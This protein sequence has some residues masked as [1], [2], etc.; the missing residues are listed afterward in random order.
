MKSNSKIM[1]SFGQ[2]NVSDD[3]GT[4]STAFNSWS[5]EPGYEFREY[6]AGDPLHKI[7]WKLTAK[8]EILMVRKD[9][10]SGI[11]RKSLVVDPYMTSV[12]QKNVKK[13]GLTRR[14]LNKTDENSDKK[15]TAIIEERVLEAALSIASLAVKTGREIEVW[16]FQNGQW[17]QY[18]IRDIKNIHE[19]QYKLAVYQFISSSDFKY[20]ERIPLYKILENRGKGR[21]STG[22]ELIVFTG[23]PDPKL[24]ESINLLLDYRMTVDMVAVRNNS[25][26]TGDNNPAVVGPVLAQ[27]RVWELKVDEDLTEAFL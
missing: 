27:G 24:I 1:M 21:N 26:N 5:G 10:G 14:L 3:T 9:E 2:V 18:I 4:S 22:G 6:Q 13:I 12:S 25:A 23:C 8:K 15:E 11:P 17:D 16:L 19:I 20:P 7:H